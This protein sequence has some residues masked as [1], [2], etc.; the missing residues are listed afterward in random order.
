MCA[1]GED[2]FFTIGALNSSA[3]SMSQLQKQLRVTSTGTPGEQAAGDEKSARASVAAP[4]ECLGK[5]DVVHVTD[6]RGDAELGLH[7]KA[8]SRRD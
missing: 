3:G 1:P 6:H 8:K 4:L 7:R 2:S 5:V